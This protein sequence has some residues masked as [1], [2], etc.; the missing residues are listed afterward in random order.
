L[1]LIDA[2]IP[3][4]EYVVACTASLANGNVPLVDI[5]HLEE[6]SGGPNLTIAALPLSGK[7]GD[8][9]TL[10]CLRDVSENVD[11]QV[12]NTV[13]YRGYSIVNKIALLS[14]VNWKWELCIMDNTGTNLSLKHILNFLWRSPIPV[15]RL[16]GIL[17][18]RTTVFFSFPFH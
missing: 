10:C 16:W 6:N 7:V 1:A 2:G 12:T 17:K 18:F 9:R 5:S 15:T 3:M 14:T 4:T 13:T 11:T 8:S